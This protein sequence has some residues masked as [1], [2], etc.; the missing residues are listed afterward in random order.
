MNRP[1][2]MTAFGRGEHVSDKLTWTMEI[3][4][5]NHKFCDV[6]IKIPRRYSFLEE[7]IRKKILAS[8]SRGRVEVMLTLAGDATETIPLKAN[9]PLATQYFQ[10][11]KQIQDQ[12]T[13]D[14]GPDLSMF[15]G[16][17]DIIIP[18]EQDE[19]LEAVWENI[20]PALQEAVTSC[21]QMRQ[22]EGENLKKDLLHMLHFINETVDEIESNIP[23]LIEK[24]EKVL[25]ERLDNLLQGVDIDPIRVAQEIAIIADKTDITEEVQRLRSHIGQ[26]ANF[27]ELDEPIGRRLDFLLQEFFR[28]INTIASKINDAAIAHKTV[29]LKNQVE[30]MREQVQNLE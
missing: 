18:V 24:K 21:L 13:L 8:F 10:C 14:Q 9:L 19:D 22:N 17:K 6:S 2:S 3:R 12:F 4:S 1:L 11:L 20:L 30:K 27:L 16:V 29:E 26:F 7:R 28:E 5:V 15:T 23:G 25:K